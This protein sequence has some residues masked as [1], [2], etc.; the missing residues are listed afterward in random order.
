MKINTII[1]KVI[2]VTK[3]DLRILLRN[4]SIAFNYIYK[5]SKITFFIK[6]TSFNLKPLSIFVL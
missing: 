1:K 3:T 4:R 5:F 2:R 6:I